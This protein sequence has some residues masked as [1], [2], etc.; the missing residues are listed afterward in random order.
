[1]S[2]KLTPKQEAFALTYVRGGSASDAYRS[3]YDTSRT[4]DKS[5]TELA[6]RLLKNV[7]VR[8]RIDE[9]RGAIAEEAVLDEAR[10]LRT[11]A[12]VA[13]FDPADLYDVNGDLLPVRE[14]PHEARLAITA[15]KTRRIAGE[16]G[17]VEEVR[18]GNRNVALDAVAK[19][20]GVH[21]RIK[22]P[23]L[24]ESGSLS[25]QG[26]AAIDAM[27]AGTIAPGVAASILQALAAQARVVEVDELLRRIESLERT[28]T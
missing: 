23:A 25:E 10:T 16:V 22:L 15:I 24:N 3:A 21:G 28:L 27:A 11:M 7:K 9:I 18:F 13:Y 1:M 5:V 14:M 20:L 19:V 12:A 6:S 2:T 4:S 8:S 17:V 26:R